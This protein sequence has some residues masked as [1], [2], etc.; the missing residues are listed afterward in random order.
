[1]KTMTYRSGRGFSPII[2]AVFVA[3]AGIFP[4]TAAGSEA[5]HEDVVA[6]ALHSRLNAGQV[7]SSKT[8]PRLTLLRVFGEQGA[9]LNLSRNLPEYARKSFHLAD[10]HNAVGY[11]RPDAYLFLEK[12]F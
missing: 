7:E 12:R 10:R 9:V 4:L 8:M 5:G 6:T 11:T 3:V 2:A 1:M